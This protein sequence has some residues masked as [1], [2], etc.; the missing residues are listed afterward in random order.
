MVR[1]AICIAL[2]MAAVG[3]IAS[4][5]TLPTR[6]PDVVALPPKADIVLLHGHIL[7]ED[8]S[9]STTQAVAILGERIVAVGTDKQIRALVGPSTRVIDLHG[10][11]ATP[12]LIDS[13]AHIAEG[14]VDEVFHI[15]LTDAKS[16]AEIA[17]LVAAKATTL[18]PGEWVLGAGWDEGK[19]SEKRL[20]T[21]ADL[22][23]AAPNNPVW[24]M[25]TTGHY[26]IANSAALKLAGITAATPDPPAGTI[27]RDA[28]GNPTGVLEEA[29][30]MTAVEKQIPPVTQDQLEAGILHIVET[31]HREGMTAVKDPLIGIARWRAYKHLADQGK[32]AEHVCVLWG[33]GATMTTAHEALEH[34]KNEAPTPGTQ[35]SGWIDNDSLGSCGAKIF[36]E[37]AA[38]HAPRGAMKCGSSTPPSPTATIAAIRS[39]I[40]S[41]IARWSSSSTRTACRSVHTPSATTPST[42]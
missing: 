9:D 19:L 30:A 23:A 20:P 25:H 24:L 1:A 16:I 32:L 10:R 7:T 11:T 42:G 41:Y 12:G 4:T 28:Q 40:P 17:K 34:I 37:A 35:M 5:Q 18:K 2:G 8:T 15:P 31:L 39:P 3:P 21:A 38:A 6:K 22:D 14:G 36:M 27:V 33:A 29:A 13:H 26:G